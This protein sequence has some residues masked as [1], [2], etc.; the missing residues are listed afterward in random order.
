MAADSPIGGHW[1]HETILGPCRAIGDHRGPCMVPNYLCM[2][3]IVAKF[4]DRVLGGK[5]E[6]NAGLLNRTNHL[7]HKP[8]EMKNHVVLKIIN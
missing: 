5:A 2:S 1:G 7:T 4:Q 6:K 8:I 3:G